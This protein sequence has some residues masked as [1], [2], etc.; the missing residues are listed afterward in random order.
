MALADKTLAE[1]AEMLK[2]Q[3]EHEGYVKGLNRAGEIVLDRSGEVFTSGDHD[4]AK[5][6][7]EQAQS[8]MQNAHYNGATVHN[9]YTITQIVREIGQRQSTGS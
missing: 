8:L 5:L 1:L 7:Y 3:S 4:N 6:L 9:E 2:E